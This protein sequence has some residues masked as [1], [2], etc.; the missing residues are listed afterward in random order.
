MVVGCLAATAVL[1]SA[2]C[3]LFDLGGS[4][5][6]VSG[7]SG[8]EVPGWVFDTYESLAQRPFPD[9]VEVL[10]WEYT[11]GFLDDRLTIVAE[12]APERADELAALEQDANPVESE[13]PPAVG[14]SDE[15]IAAALE[16]RP[17]RSQSHTGAG[18]A[19]WTTILGDGET[20]T[21]ILAA[22]EL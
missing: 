18:S 20:V 3:G 13:E 12:T 1:A 22:G 2:G 19:S 9:D 4:D 5:Q 17:I 21:V 14:V 6:V 7:T 16:R 8:E 15:R 10:G 11:S